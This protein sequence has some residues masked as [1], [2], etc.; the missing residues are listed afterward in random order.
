MNLTDLPDFDQLPVLEGLGL[1]HAWGVFGSGDELGTINLLTPE[2][3]AAA[4]RSAR[5]G[6]VHNLTRALTA[7]DP[8]F[9]GREPLRHSVYRLDRNYWDDR[10][11]NLLLQSSTH[12]DGL[13]HVQAREF[14]FWGGLKDESVLVPGPGPIG[15]DRWATRGIIGRG[16]LLDLGRH[17]LTSDPTYDP[18]RT[19]SIS[20]EELD[21][22]C[23]AQDVEI[24][25]GDVLCIRTGWMGAY[26]ALDPN[27]RR[28]AAASHEFAGLAA[29]EQ[30]ARW[31][32]NK[33]I[34]AIAGDN[35][36]VELS[37]GNREVGSLHRRVIPMLGLAV[38][39]L[40]DFE[41]L[42]AGCAEDRTWDFLFVSVPLNLPGGVGSPANAVAI[43]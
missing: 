28:E 6:Q 30:M 34:A 37:P 27:G 21:A 1:R 16:V 35:P 32:W 20:T 38:G 10:L 25:I 43:R 15:I 12:W 24:R 33:H 14:G 26:Q 17:L 9:Y 8:P 42:A 39:E 31:L 11:D 13:R 4:L 7:F 5:T 3:V 40:F 23:T 22:A 2:R 36:A 18:F 19:R 41:S 29:D